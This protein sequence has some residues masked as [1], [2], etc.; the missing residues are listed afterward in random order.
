MELLMGGERVGEE[1]DV[2]N[3][4]GFDVVKKVA[5]KRKMEEEIN[6]NGINQDNVL[7]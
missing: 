1:M 6:V 5:K 4:L 2:V 3:L 7:K